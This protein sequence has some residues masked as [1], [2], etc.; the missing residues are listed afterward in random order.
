MPQ[1]QPAAPGAVVMPPAQ[2][3][4][5]LPP[6]YYA[7]PG[8]TPFY[9]PPTAAAP[10]S[11]NRLSRNALLAIIAAGVLL[12]AGIGGVIALATKGNNTPAPIAGPGASASPRPS[13]APVTSPGPSVSPGPS[14]SA[15]PSSAP[16]SAPT[17][18]SSPNPSGTGQI[19]NVGFAQFPALAGFTA[20]AP[21]N[22]SVELDPT[23]KSGQ[24]FIFTS[25]F[26][27]AD[28]QAFSDAV[29][30]TDQQ[31]SPDA[32]RYVSTPG[33]MSGTNGV[34]IPSLSIGITE[35]ITPQNGQAFPANDGLVLAVAHSASG[36]Q[37]V[38]EIELLASKSNYQT[39]WN[40]IPSTWY[41]QVQFN[42][43]P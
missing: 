36:A 21:S 42:A 9:A 31:T 15:A 16:S 20:M 38:V 41:D 39:L 35:T 32:Q 25:S 28:N 40:D 13:S 30:K 6:T 23:D 17:P 37:I 18:T 26:Q 10:G 43:V 22:G 33:T 29:L 14:S 1:P 5:T 3:P 7:A 4:P 19:S 24:V 8:Q 2:A 11:V 12:V 34:Q 27:V